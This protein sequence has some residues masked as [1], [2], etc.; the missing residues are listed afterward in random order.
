MYYAT[1]SSDFLTHEVLKTL[2]G[3]DAM[4]RIATGDLP[5]PAMAETMAIR[6]VEASAGR[7]VFE[8]VPEFRH[9]NPAGTIHGGWFGAILDSCMSCAVQSMLPAGRAYTTLEYK[10]N[11]VRPLF[12]DGTAVLAEGT[13]LHTGR[14]TA[15]AE[16]R[17]TGVEDGKLYATGTVTCM[18]F[19]VSD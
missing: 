18:I 15:T 5:A 11:L 12:A 3:L 9:T 1:S 8:G 19:D 7:V 16:G 6:M 13:S 4:Q 10:V 2:S 14:R 17:L